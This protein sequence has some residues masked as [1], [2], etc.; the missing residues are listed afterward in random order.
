MLED[1]AG[2]STTVSRTAAV[3]IAYKPGPEASKSFG[4]SGESA[5][6]KDAIAG[7]KTLAEGLANDKSHSLYSAV[8]SSR[9]GNGADD[10]GPF[11]NL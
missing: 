5:R 6:K 9:A 8:V 3:F 11:A 7:R 1:G 2:L 4:C 10:I